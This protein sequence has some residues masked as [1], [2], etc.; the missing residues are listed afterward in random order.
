MVFST[1]ERSV[2]FGRR[3]MRKWIKGIGLAAALGATAIGAA[4]PADA[5][6][7]GWGGRHYGHYYRGGGGDAGLAIGAGILGLAAGAAIASSAGPRGYYGGGGY[8]EDYGYAPPPPPPAYSYEQVCRTYNRW[9]P[10]YGG[11]TSY[12]RCY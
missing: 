1:I 9:D 6:P 2:A 5:R 10:Y 8:Y 7:W 11:Y 12:R 3:E 4:A